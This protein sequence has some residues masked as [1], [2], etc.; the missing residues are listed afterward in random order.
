MHHPFTVPRPDERFDKLTT[1]PGAVRAVAYDMVLDGYEVGGGSLRINDPE[2]QAKM[3]EAA[4]LYCPRSRRNERFG[5]LHRRRFDYGAP[6][7]GGMAFGLDRLVMLHAGLGQHPRRHRLP[8][9][10]KT[11][12]S[13]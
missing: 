4:G 6:P 10:C 9:R 2:L 13:S 3:F 11:Q 7:H 5:F 1:D 8:A 12:A